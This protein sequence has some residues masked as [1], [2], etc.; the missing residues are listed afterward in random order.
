MQ[1]G[2]LV[3]SLSLI[4]DRYSSS[5]S[6]KFTE[7]SRQCCDRDVRRKCLGLWP[8]SWSRSPTRSRHA[9]IHVRCGIRSAKIASRPR[10]ARTAPYCRLRPYTTFQPLPQSPKASHPEVVTATVSS[11][12][13]KP[14]SA[15]LTW[16]S[17]EITIPALSG[18]CA[19]L[20]A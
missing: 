18:R 5:Q 11:S 13:T 12:F 2:D 15:C 7:R 9:N 6:E 1:A 4:I 3:S 16:V 20:S 14:T 10:I 8:R 19:C 17:M